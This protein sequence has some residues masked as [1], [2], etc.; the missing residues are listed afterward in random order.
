[1]TPRPDGVSFIIANAVDPY[2]Q[3]FGQLWTIFLPIGLINSQL[4]SEKTVIRK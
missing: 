2:L 1:L 3:T 4:I